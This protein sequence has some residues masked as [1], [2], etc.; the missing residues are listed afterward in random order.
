MECVRTP[1]DRFNDLP[2]YPF[3]SNYLEVPDSEGGKLRMHYLDEGPK[4]AAPVVLFHGEP[5]HRNGQS[6][7][8]IRAGA[9]GHSLGGAVGL[10]SVECDE[11]VTAEYVKAGRYEIEIAGKKY[12]ARA[13]LRPM[14]D[15]DGERLK[16]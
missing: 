6:I 9:Y 4:D 16:G 5:I 10:G 13:S 14:F 1:D 8:Y 2:D 15:P 3:K 12:P 11:G 7:G